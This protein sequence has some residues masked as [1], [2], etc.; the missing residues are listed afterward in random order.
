MTFRYGGHAECI[1][2]GVPAVVSG[3]HRRGIL[4][5]AYW[6]LGEATVSLAFVARLSGGC[7]LLRSEH[8]NVPDGGA[9]PT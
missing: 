8:T 4:R 2:P 7:T 9:R 1:E 3:I 5:I 6:S